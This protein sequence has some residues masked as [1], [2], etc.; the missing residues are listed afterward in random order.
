MGFYRDGLKGNN[1]K[2]LSDG[3]VEIIHQSSLEILEKIGMK[4]HNDEILNLLK[5]SGCKVDFSTKRAFVP[6]K[7]IENVL[8][9]I[10]NQVKLCGRDI[11]QDINLG[12][13]K[14]YTRTTSGAPYILDLDTQRQRKPNLKDFAQSV[15][16]VDALPNIHGVSMVHM[17]PMDI[18]VNLI[19]LYTAEASF[20]NTTKHLFYVCHNEELIEP[21][22][23]MAALIAGG[24]DKLTSRPLLCGFCEAT[25]PLQLD[26]SQAQLLIN[27]TK[28]K[29]PVYTHSHPIAGLTSPVT[30]AGET[31]QM[32]A[33]T[34]MV[35]LIAQLINPG[36][37][38]IYGTSASVPNMRTGSTFSGAPEIGLLGIA[39]AQLAKKY[40]L[41]C[42]MSCGTDSK[43]ADAQA[44]IEIIFTALPPILAGIDLLDISTIDTKLTFS[45]EQLVINNEI[46]GWIARLLRG[47][48]VDKEHLAVDLI[49]EVIHS[50]G[51][52]I[53]KEHTVKYFREELLNSNLMNREPRSEWEENG[54][55]TLQQKAQQK[56]KEILKEHKLE[57]LSE[58]IQKE[59]D[60]IILLA[61][62]FVK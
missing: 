16:I 52:F 59:I 33:E 10:P 50:G 40:N 26:H 6:K 62:K 19:D 56:V 51:S 41:P 9:E 28:R 22:I 17:V 49:R 36:T 2:V 12:D 27:Y 29:L 13:G 5:K 32:N 25:S 7:L 48:I 43:I 21:V 55:K 35:I 38:I 11:K 37:P 47:I 3:E 58:D 39:L 46:I 23:E 1:L 31:A 4:I 30:L 57:S 61:K 15:R 34:L 24:E 18:P 45:L 53:D 60:K 42:D 44:S 54:S 8:K 14:L 20:K